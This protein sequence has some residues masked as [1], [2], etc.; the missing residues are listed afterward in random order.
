M[1]FVLTIHH[2]FPLK[3]NLMLFCGIIRNQEHVGVGK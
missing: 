1:V 3:K 2:E